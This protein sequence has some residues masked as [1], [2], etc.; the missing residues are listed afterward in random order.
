MFLYLNR[1]SFLVNEKH[2][3]NGGINHKYF[4]KWSAQALGVPRIHRQIV[5]FPEV[6]S[7]RKTEQLLQECEGYHAKHVYMV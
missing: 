7:I 1:P 6:I 2:L 3:E 5:T 4:Q